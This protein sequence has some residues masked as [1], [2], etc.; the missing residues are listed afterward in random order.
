MNK[1]Q[2]CG[3]N[4]PHFFCLQRQFTKNK[5]IIFKQKIKFF[6]K[7]NQKRYSKNKNIY[8]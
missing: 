2:K 6:T 7:K 1:S 4:S 5:N 3:E 8:I